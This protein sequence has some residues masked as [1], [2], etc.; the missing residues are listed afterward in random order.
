MSWTKK[1]L[2]LLIGFGVPL[3]VG[4][5]VLEAIFGNWL[6]Q[7][8]WLV[9]RRLNIVRDQSIT[10]SVENIYG[11]GTPPVTYTRDKYGLR[12]GCAE[13]SQIDV[14]TIGGS[15]TDQRIIGDGATWQDTLQVQLSKA[16]G[17]KVC[18]SN[19]GVDGHS[20]FGHV[21][22]FRDWFSLIPRFRPKV[23]LLYIGLN[24]AGVRLEPN[25]GFDTNR[26]TGMSEL[27]HMLRNN[28]AIYQ[29]SRLIRDVFQSSSLTTRNAYAGHAR[30]PPPDSSY[31]APRTTAGV[32]P[33]VEKNTALFSE[34]L[35]LILSEIAARKG[36]PV[37]ISQP[38]LYVREFHG[39]TRGVDRVFA[40]G[41]QWFNGLDYDASVRSINKEMQR[42]CTAAEGYYIDLASKKFELS[43]FYDGVHNTPEG[44][45]RVGR[46]MFEELEKQGLLRLL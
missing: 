25:E 38:H 27:R 7:D 30:R 5:V 43:D 16:Q 18:V 32:E 24:D 15:T 1:A 28:S 31:G 34:R 40:Y 37:C 33:L 42:L 4:I 12:G 44:A 20:T 8:E 46:Y 45:G 3:L 17:R 41:D 29:L 26:I 14:V 22:A 2:F 35:A 23:Y 19:A 36:T 6:R 10:Y 13:P 11:P 39:Q 9:T 21:A